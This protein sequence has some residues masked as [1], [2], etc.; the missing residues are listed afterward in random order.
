MALA[1][2]IMGWISV[3][4]AVLGIIFVGALS[5]CGICGAFGASG[6]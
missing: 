3:G 1:G 5:V 6:Y 2:I 4:L